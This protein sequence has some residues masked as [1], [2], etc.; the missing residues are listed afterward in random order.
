MLTVGMRV[1]SVAQYRR[2]VA[3]FLTFL[4][5]NAVEPEEP[6][7]YD[8]LLVEYQAYGNAGKPVA[9]SHF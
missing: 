8:D 1:S 2:A 7:E 9:R 6:C 3:A 4:A 5:F